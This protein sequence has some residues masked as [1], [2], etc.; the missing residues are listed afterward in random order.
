M[1]GSCLGSVCVFCE[2]G[3][4][5]SGLA[6]SLVLLAIKFGALLL[7]NVQLLLRLDVFGCIRRG[8]H[9]RRLGVSWWADSKLK[10]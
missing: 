2:H 9:G 6:P 5:P 10:Q 1:V 7:L 8:E 3:Q 4:P